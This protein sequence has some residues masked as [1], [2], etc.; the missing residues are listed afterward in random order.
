MKRPSEPIHF[1]VPGSLDQATGGYRYDAA[2]VAG[3]RNL[4]HPVVV[5]ELAGTFPLV[6]AEAVAAARQARK[7]IGSERA[8][9]D[10]LALPAFA[11]LLGSRQ[12]IAGLVHHPLWLETGITRKAADTLRRL[13]SGLLKRL[14]GI[15]VTSAATR[16]DVMALGV[17]PDA[18]AVVEPGTARGATRARRDGSVRLLCV[19]TLTPRKAHAV[20]LRALAKQRRS[21]WRLLCV[22]SAVRDVGHARHLRTLATGLRLGARVR[23]AGEILP[24]QLARLYARADLFT[25]PSLHEGYGMAFA[26]AIAAGVPVIG[27]RAGALPEVVPPAAGILVPPKNVAALSRVLRQLLRSPRRRERLARGAYLHRRRFPGWPV[28]ARAFA[29]ALRP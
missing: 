28:Q 29:S 13:E 4:G 19:G 20:L 26:E 22:G 17:D 8:V 2:I 10:G 21:R 23:F 14:T 16:R 6:D 7:M 3:L 12:R 24:D 5:H 15:I 11:G 27:T 9:I 18:I 1:V 25:L